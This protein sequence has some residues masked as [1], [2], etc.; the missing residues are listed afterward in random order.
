[1]AVSD[2]EAVMEESIIPAQSPLVSVTFQRNA[3]RKEKFLEAEPK[4]LGIAEI[5]LSL[6][7]IICLGVLQSK[8][9]SD[10]SSGI[11]IFIASL[12]CFINDC[13][14]LL[15]RISCFLQLRAC[16]GMQIL[17]C[18][19][20]IVNIICT[21]VK[22]GDWSHHCWYLHADKYQEVCHQIEFIFFNFY[23]GGVLVQATVLAISASLM[24]YCCKVVNCCGPAPKMPVIMVQTPPRPESS[25]V[26]NDQTS[27]QQS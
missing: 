13:F 17:A 8:G 18:G 9:L 6:Y 21:L 2:E 7:T 15:K 5:G 14:C 25:S 10:P 24:A 11:P 22:M 27:T 12:L 19:A 16:L 23:G 26:R 4:A 1:M 20:S 3:R